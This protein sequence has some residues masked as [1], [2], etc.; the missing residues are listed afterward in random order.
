MALSRRT[1]HRYAFSHV[2]AAALLGLP[3]RSAALHAVDLTVAPAPGV[4]TRQ[5]S[6]IRQHVARLDEDVVALHGLPVTSPTRTVA[7]CL[8]HLTAHD[9]VGI[10]D[11]ALHARLATLDEVRQTLARQSGW[12]YAGVAALA[13]PM[14][15]ERRE[16]SLE[17]RSAVVMHRYGLPR[18]ESQTTIYDTRGGFVARVDFA[19]LGAAVVGEADGRVKYRDGDPIAVFEAEKD[20]QARLEALGLVVVRWGWKHLV[21]EPPPLVGRLREALARGDASRFTGRAA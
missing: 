21:G 4:R 12:P 5:Q 19:W 18:P 9:S 7:D 6:D 16:S 3:I 13:L 17:S 20:R 1:Q 14:L 11:A 8:R 2:T 10:G 15:D